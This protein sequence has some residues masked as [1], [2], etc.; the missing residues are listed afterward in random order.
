MAQ[1]SEALMTMKAIKAQQELD[2]GGF[3]LI[4]ASLK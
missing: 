3:T 1:K 2:L 4:Q